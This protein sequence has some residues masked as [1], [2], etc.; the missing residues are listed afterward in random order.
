MPYPIAK[1]A[2][3]LRC[4]L[5]ELAGPPERYNLQIAAGDFS[6]CPPIQNVIN[7]RLIFRR[8]NGKPVLYKLYPNTNPIPVDLAE[9]T[10]VCESVFT[11]TKISIENFKSASFKNLFI[12]TKRLEFECC[13]FSKNFFKTLRPF[14][15]CCPSI[16]IY[17][18]IGFRFSDLMT[19][20]PELKNLSILFTQN[21]PS[22]WLTDLLPFSGQLTRLNLQCCDN[23]LINITCD[24]LV[25]FLRAQKPGFRLFIDYIG[26]PNE[27]ISELI[28]GLNNQLPQVSEY[29]P[30]NT[31]MLFTVQEGQGE[32]YCTYYLP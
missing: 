30:R 17:K 1:L 2:Y 25:S 11:F 6:I 24:Q 5:H 15:Y 8:D 29:G 12:N 31:H 27:H 13:D 4:R 7:N 10:L 9:N 20:F 21:V 3:G 16:T 26:A 22:T 18:M 28:S 32:K 23:V 19:N 14:I